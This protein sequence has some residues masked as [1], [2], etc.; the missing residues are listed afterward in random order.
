MENVAPCFAIIAIYILKQKQEVQS[1]AYIQCIYALL[2]KRSCNQT[3]NGFSSAPVLILVF[4]K[5]SARVITCMYGLWIL[6][7]LDA[8]EPQNFFLFTVVID[9][10]FWKRIFYFTPFGIIVVHH[11]HW[12][13]ASNKNKQ[14]HPEKK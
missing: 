1:T 10:F 7:V 5:M 6:S 13:F 12:T 4:E 8:H 11:L 3:P 9:Y 14:K 2:R